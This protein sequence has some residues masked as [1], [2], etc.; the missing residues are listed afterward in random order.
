MVRVRPGR[1][2]GA[3]DVPEWWKTFAALPFKWYHAIGVI[4]VPSIAMIVYQS[5]TNPVTLIQ[6]GDVRQLRSVMSGDPKPWCVLCHNESTPIPGV[7]EATAK[8]LGN[9]MNFGVLDCSSKLPDSGVMIYK[10]WKFDL[11]TG[12]VVFV[13]GGG[14]KPVQIDSRHIRIEYDFVKHVRQAAKK[15]AVMVESAK[16]LKTRCLSKPACVVVMMGYEDLGSHS[17]KAI[18]ELIKVNDDLTFA[19][20]DSSKYMM[21]VET[22]LPKFELGENR[23]VMFKNISAGATR[24]GQYNEVPEGAAAADA[25][26]VGHSGLFAS[27]L[28]HTFV[29]YAN[30]ADAY[31]QPVVADVAVVDR[32]P[33]PRRKRAV[34]EEPASEPVK[35]ELTEEERRAKEAARR[36]EMEREAAESQIAE[37]M[38][39]H[40]E[41]VEA[42]IAGEEEGE[43]EEI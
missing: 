20:I 40:G 32:P 33:P 21:S 6:P 4:L 24:P 17:R 26:F 28:L 39:E 38:D 16:E 23:L 34:V 42:V 15:G 36:A 5:A 41:A 30:S 22:D 13:T 2:K 3:Q 9:E 29:E 11:S 35:H 10:R 43:V 14:P 25:Y 7:F 37:E 12:P 31:Y 19:M 18:E 27:H 8:R 1:G